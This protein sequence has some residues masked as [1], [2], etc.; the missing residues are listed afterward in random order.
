MQSRKRRRGRMA[1]G[2]SHGS[3]EIEKLSRSIWYGSRGC[4]WLAK[5]I[6]TP[7]LESGKGHEFVQL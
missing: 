1:T 3:L 4:V 5:R 7:H 6:N 2:H